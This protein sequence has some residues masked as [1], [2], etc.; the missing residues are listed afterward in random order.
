MSLTGRRWIYL[1]GAVLVAASVS[2]VWWP[3]RRQSEPVTSVP[4]SRAASRSYPNLNLTAIPAIGGDA[5]LAT[6]MTTEFIDTL[7]GSDTSWY[8]RHTG[9]MK[10]QHATI[11]SY[12]PTDRFLTLS[13]LLDEEG[14]ASVT[15]TLELIPGVVDLRW[16]S[17][18]DN[19]RKH[20]QGEA[21][22]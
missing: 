11:Y 14:L 7:M 20:L 2:I 4:A 9:R 21:W 3:S 17:K 15:V 19:Y 22:T 18:V 10:L 1:A 12:S 6:A 13:R 5:G 8:P 16:Q